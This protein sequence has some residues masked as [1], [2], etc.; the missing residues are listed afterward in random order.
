MLLQLTLGTIMIVATVVLHVAGV[1]LL[2]A[3]LIRR[4]PDHAVR[5]T[6]GR[7][8]K[9]LTII[10]LGLFVLHSIEIW[11]WAALYLVVGEFSE[12][13]PA[14]YFSTVTFTTLGYGDMTL[15]PDW[16]ILS[17][18][19]AANGIILFGASTAVM[20]AAF[21]RIIQDSLPDH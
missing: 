17:G 8:I 11:A 4:Y 20:L 16:R 7:S 6:T 10:T 3:R 1:V 15:G 21:R 14:V 12:L 2:I 18:I 9:I 13:S 5:L 19:E